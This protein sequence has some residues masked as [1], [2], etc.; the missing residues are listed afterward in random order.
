VLFPEKRVYPVQAM[1]TTEA[2]IDYGLRDI[3]LV[4]GDPARGRRLGG[5]QLYQALCQLAVGRARC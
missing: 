1:P 2:A 4:I 5:A 3:Y